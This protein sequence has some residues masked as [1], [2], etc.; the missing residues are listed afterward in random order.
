M[1]IADEIFQEGLRIPPVRLLSGGVINRDLWD[2]LL[3]NVRTPKEREG[4][5][6]A[7]IGANK[8]GERRLAGAVKRYGWPEVRRYIDA[9]LNYSERMT[10]LAIRSIPR[11]VYKAE[12]FLDDDGVANRPIRIQASIVIEGDR[13]TVDFSGS[14]AQVDGSLNAVFAITASVVFYVFRTLVNVA[15][16]S[17]AGGMR[18]IRIIA[19]EGSIVNAR[20]PGAVC[21]GNVETSQRLVDVLYRCLAQALPDQIPAASQGTMNNV[22]FGGRHPETGEMYAYYETVCGGM[23]AR[24]GMD[25]IS[26]VHTHMTNSMNTPVEALEHGYPV[27]VLR[28]ALRKG[29]GGKGRLR[30][31]DG[32]VRELQFLGRAQVT[33]LSDR[34]RFPPY[35]LQGG[36]SGAPGRNTALR[37][38]G[39]V[40]E[41]PAKF[42]GWF[43]AGD[44]LRIE[45]PGGGGFGGEGTQ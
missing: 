17:N 32:V 40:E 15:I 20:P 7:M 16:P 44:V 22:T 9:I 30:G 12:D 42:M 5:L 11:G 21:G 29:S 19:P 8:T 14:D 36:G 33:M 6:A 37:R 31:G 23:G 27:R 35:G 24:P 2:L 39:R 1:P 43:E 41:L 28:Y 3:L 38:D 25:G 18:P 10:R 45:T 34:R 4:D 26:G 13:A